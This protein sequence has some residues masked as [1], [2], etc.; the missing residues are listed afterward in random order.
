VFVIICLFATSSGELKIFKTMLN[1]SIHVF[2]TARLKAVL[3]LS[4][5]QQCGIHCQ[6]ICVIQLL[7]PNIFGKTWKNIYTPNTMEVY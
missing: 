2:T 7:T 1:Q 3:F 5:Y 6:M 4:P